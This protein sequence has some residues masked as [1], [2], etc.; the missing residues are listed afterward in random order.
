MYVV[1]SLVVRFVFGGSSC[2]TKNI[3]ARECTYLT[4]YYFGPTTN[5]NQDRKKLTDKYVHS[6]S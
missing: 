5:Q 2:E 1:A 6:I 3:R 4:K